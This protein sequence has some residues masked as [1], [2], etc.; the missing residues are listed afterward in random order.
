MGTSNHQIFMA[1]DDQLKISSD[2]L[3]KSGERDKQAPS[4]YLAP[5]AVATGPTPAADVWSLGATLVASPDPACAE[6]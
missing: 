4:A 1:V 2:S 3:R 6:P 5:E